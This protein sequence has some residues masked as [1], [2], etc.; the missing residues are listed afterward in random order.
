MKWNPP[1]RSVN[2]TKII[3]NKKQDQNERSCRLLPEKLMEEAWAHLADFL[4][5]F[6]IM[7]EET[8]CASELRTKPQC[9]TGHG[10]PI[11]LKHL[12]NS[13]NKCG[14]PLCTRLIGDC[15]SRYGRP[16]KTEKCANKREKSPLTFDG[17]QL[18]KAFGQWQK[19]AVVCT[20]SYCIEKYYNIHSILVFN[21]KEISFGPTLI[22]I[23]FWLSGHL[24]LLNLFIVEISDRKSFMSNC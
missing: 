5:Q 3:K 1:W 14:N 12:A 8:V 23:G 16:R 24:S 21:F 4:Q 11:Y 17:K 22:L 13:S 10:M 2:R 20:K 15:S 7:K 18:L 19:P 6:P 9:L